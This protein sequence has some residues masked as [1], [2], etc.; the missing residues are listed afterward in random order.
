M[1][2]PLTPGVLALLACAAA[3]ALLALRADRAVE[4]F[5]LDLVRG[6]SAAPRLL[7]YLA[8]IESALAYTRRRSRES[9][10]AGE[11]SRAAELASAGRRYERQTRAERRALARLR[12]VVEGREDRAARSLASDPPRR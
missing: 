4:R 9:A 11:A 3:V 8:A 5:W 1:G 12:R 2:P 7:E 6:R 10:A